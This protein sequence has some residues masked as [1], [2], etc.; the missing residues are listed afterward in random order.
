MGGLRRARY[1]QR[2][3]TTRSP[4]GREPHG[5]GV[6]VL[7][8]GV[9][10]CQGGRENRTAGRRG[11]GRSCCPGWEV[12]E[13]QDAQNSSGRHPGTRQARPAA[14]EVVSTVVQ[15]AVVHTGPTVAST[16][17]RVR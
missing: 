14:G 15:S 12:C 9:T 5:D 13:M 4:T 17:T 8:A 7:V 10:T 1:V 16:P 6:P 2:R 11:T 3:R